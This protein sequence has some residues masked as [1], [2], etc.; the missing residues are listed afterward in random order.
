[1]SVILDFREDFCSRG[2]DFDF[3]EV[4]ENSEDQFTIKVIRVPL[5][6]HNRASREVGLL[7]FK[8]E[9]L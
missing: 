7:L 8:I 1:M 4:K 3:T 2:I 6:L 9:M 5:C